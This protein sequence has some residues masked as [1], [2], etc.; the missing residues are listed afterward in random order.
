MSLQEKLGFEEGIFFWV[1]KKV[2]I[3]E[4][5]NQTIRPLIELTQSQASVKPNNRD[6]NHDLHDKGR[7]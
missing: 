4:K 2:T 7:K 6:I 3:T 5:N 1:D